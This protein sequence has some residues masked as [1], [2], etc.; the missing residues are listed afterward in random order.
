MWAIVVTL[1]VGGAAIAVPLGVLR[2]LGEA[3][4]HRPRA[5]GPTFGDGSVSFE[6]I[7]G[8]TVLQG[9]TISACATTASFAP[10]DVQESQ[11]LGPHDLLGCRWTAGALPSDG[12]LVTASADDPY[13]WATPNVNFPAA[14]LPPAF[15]P[16]TCGARSYEGQPPGTTECHV[17]IT[18]NDR[19]L[20]VT[21]WFG[22]ESP[23]GAL[24]A[25]AQAGLDALEVAEPAS[26]G[27]VVAFQP[28]YGWQDRAATPD[29][30][31][32]A[33]LPAAWTSNADLSPY[34]GDFLPAGPS[35]RDIATLPPDG[36]IV[37]AE[38]WMATRNPLPDTSEF[39][40]LTLPQQL[41]EGQL[42][43]GPWEGMPAAD[44]S[45]LPLEGVVNGRP[46][47]VQAYFH[48]ADPSP[49]LV[50]RAQIALNRLVVVPA[51]PPTHALDD[52]GISMQLPEGWRGWLF[53]GD[54]TLVAT[55]SDP[56]DPFNAPEVGQRM[57]ANDV[58]VVVD[59]SIA[60]QDLRWPPIDGPP[61]ITDGNACDGCEVMDD[62]GPPASGHVLYRNTF[63]TVGRAFDLYVEFGL[64][65][66]DQD[67]ADV[68]RIL[69]TL[70]LAP[71][72]SPE[73]TPPGGEAVGS[74]P[75][76][77]RPAVQPA[78]PDR[79]LSWDYE[80]RESMSVPEGWTGWINLVVGS[81]D[82]LNLF[83]FGSWEVP[84]GA[85]CAPLTALQQLP[86]DGAL[87]WIDRYEDDPPLAVDAVPWPN[88]P[89]VGPGT[90]P[91]PAPTR[92]TGGVPVQSFTWTLS[93]R[94]YAVQVA[95]GP[96]ID[97]TT[98]Q[99]TEAALA[100]FSASG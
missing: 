30:G 53:E 1:I 9:G 61:Q 79:T 43:P 87:V 40:S 46:L 96:A 50:N 93:G 97:D 95:F 83:A 44:V 3:K 47:I 82:P 78:D 15:D 16:S 89:Q 76:G 26:L 38:Q 84:E 21:V 18:A 17:W 6:P 14:T 81:G 33:G 45:R 73:P 8:W 59:E 5:E 13:S 58:T 85:Y 34:S 54:P 91:A 90:D 42:I 99:E 20:T 23:D 55:T 51:P 69:E 86:S 24:M 29:S 63:T 70:R 28:E 41:S 31:D 60:V 77:Q 62:G 52:F 64:P 37:S 19:T 4:T 67:L 80:G 71:N 39:H 74:L 12:V 22:T 68:N 94:T 57:G 72:P 66:S 35:N 7:R 100:S 36:V 92:C 11:R 48:T 32:S 65:P 10:Q 49:E 2:H 56:A 88:A 98:I 27:N 25:T 75:D